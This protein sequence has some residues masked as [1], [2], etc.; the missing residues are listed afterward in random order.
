M[1]HVPQ[2]CD[3]RAQVLFVFRGAG[4]FKLTSNFGKLASNPFQA[5]PDFAVAAALQSFVL[6]HCTPPGSA[7]GT[8]A[9]YFLL[10]VVRI[11]SI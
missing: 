11:P 10:D 4:R 9:Q 1:T 7:V 8:I 3:H 2:F 5:S 6:E